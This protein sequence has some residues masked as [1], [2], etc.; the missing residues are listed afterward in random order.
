MVRDTTGAGDTFVGGYV[1]AC[2]RWG[3]QDASLDA[4][5]DACR[6][7]TLAAAVS[8]QRDGALSSVPSAADV[9]LF[10]TSRNLDPG[11]WTWPAA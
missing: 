3:W 7:A 5:V 8:V 2:A 4:L 1:N 10:G 9:V 11:S 6:Y